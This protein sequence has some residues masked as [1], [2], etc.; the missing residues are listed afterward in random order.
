[1]KIYHGSLE[2]VTNPEIRMSDRTLD[3]GS[4][5]YATT[6]YDQAKRWAERRKSDGVDVGY[7]NVYEISKEAILEKKTLWFDYPSEEW[8]DFV[9]ENRTNRDFKHDYVLFTAL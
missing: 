6:D 4:G 8:A 2:I 3:Y 1:M 5:F 7:I 9:H